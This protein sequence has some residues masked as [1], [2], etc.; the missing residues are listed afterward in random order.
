[1]DMTQFPFARLLEFAASQQW[2]AMALGLATC[3]VAWAHRLGLPPAAL[4]DHTAWVASPGILIAAP[5]YLW[6][7]L[8]AFDT[9]RVMDSLARSAVSDYGWFHHI[10]AI[11]ISQFLALFAV[12]LPGFLTA[13]SDDRHV[14][15]KEVAGALWA[16]AAVAVDTLL[17]LLVI[18]PLRRGG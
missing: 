2:P 14:R 5:V 7:C 18:T 9:L 13:I 17:F 10:W 1:M 12:V 6:G 11:H 15:F 3:A 8:A 16:V 4:R